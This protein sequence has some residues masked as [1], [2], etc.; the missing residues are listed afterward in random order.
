[1]GRKRLEKVWDDLW[2]SDEL[3]RE[4]EREEFEIKMRDCIAAVLGMYIFDSDDDYE[5]LTRLDE[6]RE[7]G[8]WNGEIESLVDML[9]DKIR[10]ESSGG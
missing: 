10:S 9:V 2:E 3:R 6:M 4:R 8:T 7:D 1:M 5:S